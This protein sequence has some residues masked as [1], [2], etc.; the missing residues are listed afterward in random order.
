MGNLNN[1][2]SLSLNFCFDLKNLPETL[3]NLE[4]LT[5]L[6]LGFCNSITDLPNMIGNITSLKCLDFQSCISIEALPESISE[7]KNLEKLNA[8]NCSLKEI[9][10]NLKELKNLQTLELQDNPFTEQQDQEM[11]KNDIPVIFDYLK[12]KSAINVF[13]SHAVIDFHEY[14]IKEFAEYL[15][16]QKEIYQAYFCEEDLV[17]NIDNFMDETIPECQLVL[18]IAT[19]KSV[20][21]SVDCAHELELARVIEIQIIPIKGS[22]LNWSE[23]ASIG[24]S[25]ELGI[26]FNNEDFGAFC[27]DVYQYIYDFKRKIDL[28][29][30]Q[31]GKMEKLILEYNKVI[32]EHLNSDVYRESF[33]TNN[34]ELE[35]LKQNLRSGTIEFSSFLEKLGNFLKK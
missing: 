11:A 6:N 2:Q 19:K 32:D 27:R 21:N 24:L 20:F 33:M 9:P 1:L 34:A 16:Q 13:I 23:L 4:N 18:F 10:V 30:K 15:E 26:E 17:G 7:L 12:R 22:D 35:I 25:R 8:K 14:K 29:D 31:Q 5:D 28:F 3:C